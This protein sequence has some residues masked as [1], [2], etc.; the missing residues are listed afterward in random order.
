[1]TTAMTFE[2]AMEIINEY[3]EYWALPGILETLEHMNNCEEYL[4]NAEARTLRVAMREFGK[5]FATV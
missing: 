4:S 2:Q 5:L 3:K 1:M